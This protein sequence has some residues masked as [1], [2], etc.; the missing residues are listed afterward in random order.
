MKKSIF[1]N[2]RLSLFSL[3]SEDSPFIKSATMK[4][5]FLIVAVIFTIISAIPGNACNRWNI[6]G[7]GNMSHIYGEKSSGGEPLYRWGAGA[8]IGIG[9]EVRFTSRFSLTPALELSYIDNGSA[10][11]NHNSPL[12]SNNIPWLNSYTISM[13]VIASYRIP[14][15]EN[16][17]FR[18]G[19][20]IY[21][22]EALSGKHHALKSD[23]KEALS[24]NASP[25]FNIGPIGEAAI[26]TGRHI[27]YIL[28]AQYP[29]SIQNDA[30]ITKTLTMSAGIR[31]TF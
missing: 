17:S 6:Y 16:T 5:V 12:S 13:P 23:K 18:I 24:G 14:I 10:T 1:N 30:W 20:G 31:Y 8:F 25:R 15:S 22:Q 7:G 9:Y 27:S 19:G 28:R 11:Q 26:E 3:F 29:F 21:I 2:R 4:R